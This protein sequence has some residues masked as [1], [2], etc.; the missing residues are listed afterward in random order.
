MLEV[1]LKAVGLCMPCLTL[2]SSYMTL[3]EYRYT[4]LSSYS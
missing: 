4:M 1:A 3:H 2:L